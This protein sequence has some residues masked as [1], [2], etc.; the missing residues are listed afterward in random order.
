MTVTSEPAGAR[1]AL[2]QW[3]EGHFA[4]RIIIGLI[5]LNG[6]SLGLETWPPAMAAAGP[7][8]LAFDRAVLAVF[9][10]EIAA[11]LAYRGLAFFR[12]GWNVFDFII[13]GIALMPAAGPF[14]VMRALR[15]LRVLRLV[16]AVPTMRRVVAALLTAIP[17]LA[18]VGSIILLCFYV[19]AV[20]A[21]KLFGAVFPEWFGSIGRSMYTLFQVM[22]LES[23]SMGIVRP[24][25]AAFPSAWLFF[26]PFIVVTSFAILNLFI[27]IIVD[28]L[29]IVHRQEQEAAEG[30][31][32]I[33]P[34][35]TE[36]RHLRDEIRELKALIER[37]T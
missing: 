10:A 32:K 16:S 34:V 20:L 12:S 23:W 18:A 29:Q 14:A 36:L 17:G 28:A 11:K 15:I 19:G 4:Q 37:R 13:V 31:P 26:V 6:I 35:E 7:L 33:T 22:T 24:V 21:T 5:V 9:V 2:G 1:V 3:V 8:L 30:P 25:M 27:G